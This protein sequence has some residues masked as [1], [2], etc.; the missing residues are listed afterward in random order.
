MASD[1]LYN[2]EFQCNKCEKKVKEY[3]WESSLDEKRK[4]DCKKKGILIPVFEDIPEMPAIGGKFKGG[5]SQK[6]KAQRRVQS[7]KNEVLPEIGGWEKKHFMKKY[8]LK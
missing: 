3:V 1:R 2:Q 4:C 5:R 6:E 7:F 8:G